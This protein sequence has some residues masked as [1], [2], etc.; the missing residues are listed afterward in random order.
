MTVRKGLALALAVL[1]GACT[2]GRLNAIGIAGLIA[3]YTF[4]EGGGTVVV[5]HSGNHYDG[6]L[7]GGATWIADG[8]FGGALHF[9]GQSYVSVVGFPDAPSSFS[10]SAW[11]RVAGLASDA[12]LQTV[13]STEYVFDGGWQLNIGGPDGG[14]SDNAGSYFQAAFWDRVESQYTYSNCTCVPPAVWT[15]LAFVV[16]GNAHSMSIYVNGQLQSVVQAPDPIAPGDSTLSMGRWSMP[17]RML[18]GDL[19][20]LTVFGRALTAEE[21]MSLFQAPVAD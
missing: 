5:D 2:P 1:G 7:G 11:V 13:A 9:D 14:P 12:G 19:D 18:A 21:V 4:D 10:V 6:Q 17:G 20:D 3:H 15:Q 16:D 8:R